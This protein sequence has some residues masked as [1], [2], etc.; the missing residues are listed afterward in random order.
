M[1]PPAPPVLAAE[2]RAAVAELLREQAV[3]GEPPGFRVLVRGGCMTPTLRDGQA[4]HV[5]R[6]S[7]ALPGDIV[8]F[9]RGAEDPGLAVHRLLGPRPSRTGLVWVTQADN[10]SAPDPAFARER[11]LGVAEVP[12]SLTARARALRRWLPALLT[13]VTERLPLLRVARAARR[14]PV[15]VS[16]SASR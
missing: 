7:W 11:L 3:H 1:A 15:P 10:E 13:P 4:V 8:A 5:R 12:V 2:R 14:G 9:E 6:R 16:P